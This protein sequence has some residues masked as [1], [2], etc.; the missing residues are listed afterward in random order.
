MTLDF[1]SEYI[2]NYGYFV[3]FA[4]LFIAMIGIPAPEETFMLLIGGMLLD[5][6]L[7]FFQV[8]VI[9]LLGTNSAMLVTYLAG[10][11]LGNRLVS[12]YGHK[13]HIT[14]AK[15]E[16]MKQDLEKYDGIA[17]VCTYFLPGVRQV[18]PYLSGTRKVPYPVFLLFT[19]TG[20]L[21]WSFFYTAVGYYLGNAL[22][23]V[24]LASFVLAV[25]LLFAGVCIS[26]WITKNRAEQKAIAH[27]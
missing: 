19:F 16:K 6:G 14:P 13:F 8:I 12:R 17:T 22:G 23:P 27:K 10:R 2:H 5:S 4:V 26:K 18:V 20:S 25:S 24:F 15:W 11:K 3:V 21:L 9:A 1:V 7:T